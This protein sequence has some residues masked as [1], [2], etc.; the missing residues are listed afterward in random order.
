MTLDLY[1]TQKLQVEGTNGNLHILLVPCVSMGTN[2]TIL[3]SILFYRDYKEVKIYFYQFIGYNIL[4][5]LCLLQC[6]HYFI[7]LI[8]FLA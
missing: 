1:S 4:Y 6:S 7:H 5:I 8:L 2:W 3:P